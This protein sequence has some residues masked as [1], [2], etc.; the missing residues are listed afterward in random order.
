MQVSISPWR[1]CVPLLIAFR[2]STV[3]D[4]FKRWW[5]LARVTAVES[6]KAREGKYWAAICLEGEKGVKQFS[7]IEQRVPKDNFS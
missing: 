4:F 5:D 1:R 7:K 3:R 6:R 2:R